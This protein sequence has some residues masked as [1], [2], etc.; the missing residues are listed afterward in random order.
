MEIFLPLI[1]QRLSPH[2]IPR[3]SGASETNL[4]NITFA[5]GGEYRLTP[6]MRANLTYSHQPLPSDVREREREIIAVLQPRLSL[7]GWSNPDQEQNKRLRAGCVQ[8]ARGRD[9]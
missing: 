3:S 8:E 5:D 1:K 2:A 6:W 4:R 7:T 9:Q